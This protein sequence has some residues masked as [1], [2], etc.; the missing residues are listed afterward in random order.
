MAKYIITT[1]NKNYNGVTDGVAFCEGRA[2]IED[3]IKA[4]ELQNNRGYDVEV[5]E[6]AKPQNSGD[7]TETSGT[8][9]KSQK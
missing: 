1:P 4:N 5:I 9:K 8:A 2:V 3:V 7:E 6:D